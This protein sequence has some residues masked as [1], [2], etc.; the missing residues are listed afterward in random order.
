ME[1]YDMYELDFAHTYSMW[2]GKPIK[3]INSEYVEYADGT[4]YTLE[5]VKNKMLAIYKQIEDSLND[6]YDGML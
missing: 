6:F 5:E 4:R 3:T 1:Q 2:T